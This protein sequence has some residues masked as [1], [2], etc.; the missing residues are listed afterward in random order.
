[1]D[2]VLQESLLLMGEVID[3]SNVES[4]VCTAVRISLCSNWFV[5]KTVV[6]SVMS[7]DK[8]TPSEG[9]AVAVS[10]R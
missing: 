7:G 1:M 5:V 4:S 9:P 6:S 3:E 8:L 10:Q 2:V